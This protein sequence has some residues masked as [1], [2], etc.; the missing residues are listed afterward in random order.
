MAQLFR[1][2]EFR[3]LLILQPLEHLGGVFFANSV[4]DFEGLRAVEH[5]TRSIHLYENEHNSAD[6]WE[7]IFTSGFEAFW[8]TYGLACAV[9][10]HR[11]HLLAT[12]FPTRNFRNFVVNELCEYED[13][14]I[15][16][17]GLI[18]VVRTWSATDPDPL[19]EVYGRV[20]D[21][22][23]LVIEKEPIRL[24]ST[25]DIVPI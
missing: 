15:V 23:Y 25:K 13:H 14:D 2:E 7:P 4:D 12:T 21:N 19:W 24:H 16:T 8:T 11:Q 22:P 18:P 9:K 10:Q 20:A 5:P 3:R 1:I 17:R 6:A